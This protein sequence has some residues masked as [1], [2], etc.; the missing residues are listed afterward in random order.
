MISDL[1]LQLSLYSLHIFLLKRKKVDLSFHHIQVNKIFE[2][3]NTQTALEDVTDVNLQRN[4]PVD[5]IYKV[6]LNPNRKYDNPIKFSYFVS[7]L[8]CIGTCTDTRY[9]YKNRVQN[10]YKN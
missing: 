7:K 4:Y 2:D 9:E 5:D 3:D 6:R 8:C 10:F 1:T